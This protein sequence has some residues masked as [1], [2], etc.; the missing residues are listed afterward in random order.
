MDYGSVVEQGALLAKIDDSV[1]AADLS[2]AKARELSAAASLEQMTAKLD[3]ADAEWKRAQELFASKLI[4]QVD[5]DTAKA[6]YEVAKA[7]V[8]VARFGRRTGEGRSGKGAAQ[9]GFLHH[10]LARQRRHH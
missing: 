6:N 10:Q 9:S 5:Y 7:N 2:V 8:S 3:Q 1:Y 4:S